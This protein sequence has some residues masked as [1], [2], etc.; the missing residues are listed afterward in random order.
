M[1][2]G[3]DGTDASSTGAAIIGLVDGTPC[4]TSVVLTFL[5]TNDGTNSPTER[6]RI[7]STARFGF[8]TINPTTDYC[9][10][11][12]ADTN[13]QITNNTTVLMTVLVL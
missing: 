4:T 6:L 7:T 2:K 9:P 3:A 5:I 12:Q 13:I 11:G 1:F 8:N 10:S